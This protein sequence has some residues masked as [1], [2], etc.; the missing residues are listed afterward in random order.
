MEIE[1]KDIRN[2][3]YNAV[4]VIFFI[5]ESFEKEPTLGNCKYAA[6]SNLNELKCYPDYVELTSWRTPTVKK[7]D[8]ERLL[9]LTDDM[10][11]IIYNDDYIIFD[12]ER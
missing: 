10:N 6:L 9:I 1:I 12:K 2:D 4:P 3:P 5:P 7:I 11:S 8:C